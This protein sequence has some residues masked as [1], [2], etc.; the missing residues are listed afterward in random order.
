MRTSTTTALAL[1]PLLAAAQSPCTAYAQNPTFVLNNLSYGSTEQWTSP[2][3]GFGNAAVSFTLHNNALDPTTA[4]SAT[5]S[6][7]PVYF[8]GTK[9]FACEDRATW[10]TFSTAGAYEVR[11]NQTYSCT[12]EGTL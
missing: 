4:C 11:V 5:S 10:F 12:N 7:N 1:A 3:H 6:Q 8:D 2:A 9:W